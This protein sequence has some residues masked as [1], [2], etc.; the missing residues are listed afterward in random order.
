MQQLKPKST[1]NPQNISEG[2]TTTTHQEDD[3]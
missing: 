1:N 2:A 3:A